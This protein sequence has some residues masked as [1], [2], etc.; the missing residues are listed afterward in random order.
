MKANGVEVTAA[1]TAIRQRHGC[2]SYYVGSHGTLDPHE[3]PVV[4]EFVLDDAASTAYVWFRKAEVC[5]VLKGPDAA[6]PSAATVS[7]T[8]R[9]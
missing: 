4:H 1:K 8:A 3:G 9:G 5:V 2:D 7:R 6:S